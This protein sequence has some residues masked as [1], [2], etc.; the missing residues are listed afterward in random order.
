MRY[1]TKERMISARRIMVCGLGVVVGSTSKPSPERMM[2]GLEQIRATLG[3]E[4]QSAL[5]DDDIKASLYEYY[6]N[7]EQAIEDL[8]GQYRF[9]LQI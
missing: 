2:D 9:D 3:D 7:V 8:L 1:R 6:F 4:R 5:T